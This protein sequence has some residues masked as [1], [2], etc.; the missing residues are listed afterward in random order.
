MLLRRVQPFLR[1]RAK[2]VGGVPPSHAQHWSSRKYSPP[3]EVEVPDCA[4]PG[5]M[6]SDAA[7]WAL[8]RQGLTL[9]LF[10]SL[11]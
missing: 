6:A 10:F 5:G 1:E 3:G 2:E 9:V 8:P 11:T 4:G 7:R